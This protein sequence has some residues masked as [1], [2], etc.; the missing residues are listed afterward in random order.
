MNDD[1]AARLV[2]GA[3][4]ASFLPYVEK[5]LAGMEQAIETRVFRAIDGG[6]FTP[7]MAMAAWMEKKA[8]RSLLRRLGVHVRLGEG[9][10]KQ[11]NP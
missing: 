3:R 11:L 6:T 10:A 8:C 1:D 5:E 4:V 9:A 2:E 7:D